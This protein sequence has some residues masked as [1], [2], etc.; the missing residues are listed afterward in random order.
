MYAIEAITFAVSAGFAV[1]LVATILVIIGIARE[2]RLHTFKRQRPPTIP[3]LL[4]RRI[5]G[6]HVRRTVEVRDKSVTLHKWHDANTQTASRAGDAEACH[7]FSFQAASRITD[8]CG[9]SSAGF[10]IRS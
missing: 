3:A 10:E 9:S 6:V 1:V 7:R 8:R 2:E 5:L 4:A